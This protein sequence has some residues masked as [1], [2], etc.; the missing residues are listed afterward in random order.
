MPACHRATGQ[1]CSPRFT[2]VAAE[3]IV[4]KHLGNLGILA[5]K[6]SGAVGDYRIARVAAARYDVSRLG[7][8]ML[9]P[10][11]IQA[12]VSIAFER[13]PRSVRSTF[14]RAHGRAVVTR[15]IK[16]TTSRGRVTYDV[17]YV[18]SAGHEQHELLPGMRTRVAS[19]DVLSPDNPFLKRNARRER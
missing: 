6:S 14:E 17:H 7:G 2:G 1:R 19:D 16:E 8:E 4:V 11:R 3:S 10:E 13:V 12:I 15:V 9:S 5:R 18:D